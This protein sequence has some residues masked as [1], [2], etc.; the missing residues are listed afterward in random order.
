MDRR[1]L[2][3][4]VVYWLAV[5][6]VSLAVLVALILLLESRDSSSIDGGAWIVSAAAPTPT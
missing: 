5:L 3:L 6:V 4:R 2:L 1:K